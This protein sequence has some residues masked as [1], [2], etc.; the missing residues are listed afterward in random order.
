MVN[1]YNSSQL[2]NNQFV[3]PSH[4]SYAGGFFLTIRLC[5]F[6]MCVSYMLDTTVFLKKLSVLPKGNGIYTN[7]TS[8]RSSDA[9]NTLYMSR[10]FTKV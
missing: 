2:R 1:I 9:Y 6:Y 8:G 10:C 7:H 5:I 4:V 3:R